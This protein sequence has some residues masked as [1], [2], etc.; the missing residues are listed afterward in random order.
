M[1]QPFGTAQHSVGALK[2]WELETGHE[3]HTLAGHTSWVR[4]VAV[5]PDGRRAVSA[6][7]DETLKVWELETGHEL[8]TLA[9]HTDTVNAV[10]VTPDGTP[11][12]AF[13]CDARHGSG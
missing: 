9:G 8:H 7:S 12:V 10:A 11:I 4:A 6:S 5:T 13:S 2:V 1:V 3:L